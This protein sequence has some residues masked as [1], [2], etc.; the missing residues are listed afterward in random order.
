[1]GAIIGEGPGSLQAGL[2]RALII[3]T[4]QY[5]AAPEKLWATILFT[6]RGWG[7]R[8]TRSSGWSSCA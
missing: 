2:G 8:A 1:M 4:Q 6:V 5:T 3:F 7:S